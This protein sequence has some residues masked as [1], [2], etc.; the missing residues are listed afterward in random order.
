MEASS[1]RGALHAKIEELIV[2]R[3][4]AR[5]RS[6]RRPELWAMLVR[7]HPAPS[8]S[9]QCRLPLIGHSSPYCMPKGESPEAL[10]LTQSVPALGLK[11]LLDNQSCRQCH[12][13]GAAI[14]R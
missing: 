5:V 8:L 12:Q 14:R 2:E 1:D 4:F 11:D 7:D 9:R 13:P 3:F 10:V 6:M